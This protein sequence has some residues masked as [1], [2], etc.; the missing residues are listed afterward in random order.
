M[1]YRSL[2]GEPNFVAEMSDW[3]LSVHPSDAEFQFTP[4]P[5]AERL[6]LGAAV[7]QA[8]GAK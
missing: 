2:P 1:T 6:T 3:N 5:G 8:T 4:P 7:K